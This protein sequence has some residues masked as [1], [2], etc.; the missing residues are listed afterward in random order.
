MVNELR[1]TDI[2]LSS[3]GKT[4]RK[5]RKKSGLS[6]GN[7]AIKAGLSKGFISEVESSHK[8]PRLDTLKRIG[9][10]LNIKIKLTF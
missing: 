3:L 5:I 6:I 7:L 10:A 9:R 4:L 1:H 2:E 8:V